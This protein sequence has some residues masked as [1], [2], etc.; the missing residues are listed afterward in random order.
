MRRLISKLFLL[1]KNL[2]PRYRL[3]LDPLDTCSF[4]IKAKKTIY[5]FKVFNEFNPIHLSYDDIKSNNNYLYE[6]N[7]HD[8]IKI[9][10]MEREKSLNSHQ[11]F[12]TEILRNNTFKIKDGEAE[13]IFTGNEI[14]SNPLLIDRMKGIDIYKIAFATGFSNGRE[15][16]KDLDL[17]TEKPPK[18]A[19]K[20]T[21]YV[22]S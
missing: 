13:E 12:L 21:F 10:A 14:C 5:R 16:S 15:F 19:K 22:V 7:P 2:F 11:L 4:D 9:S 8:L 3:T 17:N 20:P 1:K 6:I 18:L